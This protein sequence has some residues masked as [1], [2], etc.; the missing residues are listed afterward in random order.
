MGGHASGQVPSA[1]AFDTRSAH[2]PAT[3]GD[4]NDVPL[5][6]C[7]AHGAVQFS[8]LMLTP[9]AATCGVSTPVDGFIHEEKGAMNS[10]IHDEMRRS[11]KEP[12]AMAL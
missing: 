5:P 6:I 11:S 8:M 2:S 1:G 12:T 9:G 10:A 7:D 3:S 4:E